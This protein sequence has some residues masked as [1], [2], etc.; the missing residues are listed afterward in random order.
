MWSQILLPIPFIGH[1]Y[2]ISVCIM[3][4]MEFCCT[5]YLYWIDEQPVTLWGVG[6]AEDIC[7]Y[8]SY[9]ENWR[10]ETLVAVW[11][12]FAAGFLVEEV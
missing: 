4:R 7:L 10:K 12:A 8:F 9:L 2:R 11:R 1:R 5:I 6:N 3:V